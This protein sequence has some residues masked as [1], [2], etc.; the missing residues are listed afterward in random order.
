VYHVSPEVEIFSY[1]DDRIQ[2]QVCAIERRA[3]PIANPFVDRQ[4]G[5]HL[6]A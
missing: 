6:A 2:G 1:E 4:V 3:R 5:R